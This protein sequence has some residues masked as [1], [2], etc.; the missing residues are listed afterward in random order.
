VS[1]DS[2]CPNPR[3]RKIWWAK[4]NRAMEEV[5]EAE[6]EALKHRL[7]THRDGKEV[8]IEDWCAA[9]YPESTNRSRAQTSA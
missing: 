3:E 7:C 1:R 5:E 4:V 6:F 9:A 2:L 8:F